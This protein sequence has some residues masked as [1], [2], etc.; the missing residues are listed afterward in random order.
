[1]VPVVVPVPV[2]EPKPDPD[3]PA[4]LTSLQ[5]GWKV[6]PPRFRSYSAPMIPAALSAAQKLDVLKLYSA[7]STGFPAFR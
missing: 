7:F 6:A 3:P 4:E 1:M 2:G 5:H